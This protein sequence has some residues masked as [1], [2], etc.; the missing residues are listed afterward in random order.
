MAY[1][2][3]ASAPPSAPVA[4][5]PLSASGVTRKILQMP[6]QKDMRFEL[7][8]Y[9]A[10]ILVKTEGESVP[11]DNCSICL[12]RLKVEPNVAVAVNS[13]AAAAD[14][15]MSGPMPGMCDCAYYPVK[16]CC[17]HHFHCCC[18]I[19]YLKLNR[20]KPTCPMCRFDFRTLPSQ[21]T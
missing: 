12:N 4:A 5:A 7:Y 9:N 15:E 11:D 3:T 17:S 8:L 20:Y 19:Y 21:K 13:S 2:L 18:I 14:I 10:G 16:T 1:S 6:C